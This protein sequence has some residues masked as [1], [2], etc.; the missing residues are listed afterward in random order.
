MGGRVYSFYGDLRGQKRCLSL[1]NSRKS[2]IKN[3]EVAK[4]RGSFFNH[5]SDASNAR[6][7]ARVL[8]ASPRPNKL[9][10]IRCESDFAR[11]T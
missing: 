10:A 11:W 2:P 7:N 3:P 5:C 8:S 4:L 1:I 6:S 9:L